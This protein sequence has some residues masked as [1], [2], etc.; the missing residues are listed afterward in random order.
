VADIEG[1]LEDLIAEGGSAE[2]LVSTLDGPGWRTPTPAEGW[3]VA[4]QIAHLAW[5]DRAAVLAATDLDGFSA[6]VR[7][8]IA[9]P[10]GFVNAGAE[11]GAAQSPAALLENWRRGRTTLVAALRTVPRG[12]KLPW[13]GPPMGVASMVTGRL[14]ETWAH[15][16]DIADAL[17]VHREPT[18]RLRNVAHI[19]V[20]TIDFA[21]A[22][23][24]LEAP[25]VPFRIELT[26][27]SGELWTWGPTESPDRITGPVLDFCLLVTQR[28]HPE[29]LHLTV[30]GPKATDW[31]PIAQAFAGPPGAGRKPVGVE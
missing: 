24:G 10:C 5:T 9:D 30:D 27:P 13:F 8:A 26:G 21:F 25:E 14:M 12:T 11:R 31:V 20:R 2:A 1:L 4:H 7:A 15:G 22:L 23:H 6:E 17:G 28:R 19:G 16:E 3:T 29:D 18:A